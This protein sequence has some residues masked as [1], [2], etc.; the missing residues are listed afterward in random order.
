[1]DLRELLPKIP[2]VK[3][4]DKEYELVYSTRAMLLLE[5][6]YPTPQALAAV[7]QTIESGMKTSD[8]INFLQAGLLGAG[9]NIDK[10]VLIDKLSPRYF[11]DYAEAIFKGFLNSR[12]TE[13][14]LEKLYVASLQSD[15]KKV[16]TKN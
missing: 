10:E 14:Q 1:M 8:I 7:I 4:D 12:C 11:N 5:D 16:E 13:E 6:Y 9:L 3:I 15:K 2:K